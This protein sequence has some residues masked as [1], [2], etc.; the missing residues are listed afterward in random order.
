[1]SGLRQFYSN[2]SIF[3]QGKRAASPQILNSMINSLP[4]TLPID[5]IAA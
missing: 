1:M 3:G 4:E 2:I 5:F